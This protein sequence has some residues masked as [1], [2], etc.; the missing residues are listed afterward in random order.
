LLTTMT[1]LSRKQYIHHIEHLPEDL[2]DAVSGLSD[3][4]LDTPYRSGGWKNATM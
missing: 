1:A 2:A 4:Q 3:E